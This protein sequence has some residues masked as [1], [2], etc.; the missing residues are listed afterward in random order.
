MR[1]RDAIPADAAREV[2]E[3]LARDL[4]Y[5]A[6][7]RQRLAELQVD[8]DDPARVATEK[9]WDSMMS[10]RMEF[11]YLATAGTGK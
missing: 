5:V 8:H 3:R 6:R 2:A 4:G 11:H 1:A 9:A 7:L 10:L